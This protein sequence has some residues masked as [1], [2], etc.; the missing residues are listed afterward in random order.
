[1]I[2]PVIV[3]PKLYADKIRQC[4]APYGRL[5]M[6]FSR[7]E[8]L[9]LINGFTKKRD[10]GAVR[11][12][13]DLARSEHPIA[14]VPPVPGMGGW[15]RVAPEL[16]AAGIEARKR[17]GELPL[18]Y[19]Q[20]FVESGWSTPPRGNSELVV[21]QAKGEI[22]GYDVPE[23]AGWT[24]SSSPASAGWCGLAVVDE[25]LPLMAPLVGA[26]P[27]EHL[28]DVRVG[29]IGLGSIGS[30]AAEALASYGIRN[31][32]LIDPDRLA[33]HNFARHRLTRE[34]V[35]RLKVNAMADHLRRRDPELDVT[36]Y[37]L[38][39][40][41]DADQLRPL[42]RDLDIVLVS[43][44][45]VDPRRAANH[46]I[47]KAGKPAVFAC[48][49]EDGAFGEVMRFVPGR[50]GCLLCARRVLRDEE[51]IRPETSLDRGYGAGTRHLPMTAVTGDLGLIGD[52]AAKVTVATLLPRHWEQRLPG[53]HLVVGLRPKP[54]R[55]PP[56]RMDH[57]GE[58]RWSELPSPV[59][60][61]PSCS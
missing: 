59:A 55:R 33:P 16:H 56:F 20:S 8:M 6:K 50:T 47:R 37:V 5:D 58:V 15:Y 52:I 18:D 12:M 7:A 51:G 43:A 29:L 1:M 41:H 3:L 36:P 19:F 53:G 42:I 31:F 60:D 57:A 49:L 27:I 32:S 45:G 26:W 14:G 23:F 28:F 40:I 38:D 4:T 24:L 34:H 35:G 13:S 44:D 54:G 22:E 30:A 48:V 61:C 9:A 39:V 46:L 21:T 10:Q 11:G 2:E 25:T 17:S